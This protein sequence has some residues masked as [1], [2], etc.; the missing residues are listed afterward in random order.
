MVVFFFIKNSLKWTDES[1]EL[2][3]ELP[4]TQDQGSA[5]MVIL[6]HFPSGF[7]L[8]IAEVFES[9]SCISGHL[10]PPTV[11]HV[12]LKSLVFLWP[13]CHHRV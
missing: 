1:K 4:H 2:H 6:P 5:V 9:I 12:S 8:L 3:E 7:A 13:Q 10:T 11:V